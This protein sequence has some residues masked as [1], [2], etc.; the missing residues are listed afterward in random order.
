MPSAQWLGLR[1]LHREGEHQIRRVRLIH[2]LL[3]PRRDGS[4]PPHQA[5]AAQRRAGG[6]SRGEARLL[7]AR[8][9]RR[10]GRKEMACGLFLRH[11]EHFTVASGGSLQYKGSNTEDQSEGTAVTGYWAMSAL[12]VAHLAA[13][14]SGGQGL[15]VWVAGLSAVGGAAV[16]LLVQV[17]SGHN[18][19]R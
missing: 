11:G 4:T 7:P 5:V 18:S 12:S 6:D 2:P 1:G 19:N 13:A 15:P 17:V 8:L 9:V 3:Q 14:S 16:T 10:L